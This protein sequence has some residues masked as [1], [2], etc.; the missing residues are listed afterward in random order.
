MKAKLVKVEIL[1]PDIKTFIFEPEKR[2]TYISGQ[3]VEITIDHQPVDDRGNKRW[4]T[5]SSSPTET[6]VAITTRVGLDGSSFKHALD[7]LK[8]GQSVEMSE[9]MGDFVLPKNQATP[10]FFVAGGMGITPFKSI[11]SWLV[12]NAQDRQIKLLHAVKSTDDAVFEDVFAAA[13]IPR[14]VFVG[15]D[16]HLTSRDIMDRLEDNK[17]TLLFISGPEP[18]VEKLDYDLKQSGY[19]AS[20]IVC[21]FF[22]GYQPI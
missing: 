9:P 22:P 12:G 18:M 5:L 19:P 20:K 3:F 4:F 16:K 7:S 14:E 21:D 1:Q 17:N 13:N 6:Y 10:L 11:A 8:P 15:R 2:F